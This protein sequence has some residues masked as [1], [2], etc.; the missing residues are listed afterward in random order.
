[1]GKIALVT[2]G[3]L[4]ARWLYIAGR[5][6]GRHQCRQAASRQATGVLQAALESWY[7]E[8]PEPPLYCDLEPLASAIS[9]QVDL[10]AIHE[11]NLGGQVVLFHTRRQWHLGAVAPSRN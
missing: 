7:A 1:M 8:E 4:L 6:E 2:L 11:G 10:D 5:L 9:D 3:A